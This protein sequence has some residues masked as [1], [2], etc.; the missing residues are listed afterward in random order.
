MKLKELMKKFNPT[1]EGNKAKR[2]SWNIRVYKDMEFIELYEGET[3]ES[4]DKNLLEGEVL[5]INDITVDE[6]IFVSSWGIEYPKYYLQ[7]EVMINLV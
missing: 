6:R 4:I 1:V 2:I 5:N 3:K 7:V